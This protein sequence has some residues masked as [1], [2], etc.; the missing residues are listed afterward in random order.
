MPDK[1]I[2]INVQ[3]NITGQIE[4]NGLEHQIFHYHVNIVSSEKQDAIREY[5]RDLRILKTYPKQAASPARKGTCPLSGRGA[6]T[7]HRHTGPLHTPSSRQSGPGLRPLPQG[8]GQ[9][10]RK[11]GDVRLA[12]GSGFVRT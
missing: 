9:L 2:K 8:I 5:D 10:Q 7:S 11:I 6:G 12:H 3:G 4:H 1:S